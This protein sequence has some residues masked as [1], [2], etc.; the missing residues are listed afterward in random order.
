MSLAD[1]PT[2]EHLPEDRGETVGPARTPFQPRDVREGVTIGGMR[3]ERELAR[4]G[5]GVVYLAHEPGGRA[6]ALK[7]LQRHGSP[8]WLARFRREA[9]IGQRLEHPGIVRVH[10]IGQHEGFDYLVMELIEDAR[11]L[12][13]YVQEQGLDPT[14]RV[15]LM[16]QVC[17]ALQ[18]AHEEGVI[19]RD[20]KP[21]NLLVTPAGQV[22]VVDFGVAR[23]LE[24]SR[25][26]RTGALVGTPHFMAPEQVRHGASVAD[27][28]S[29]VFALGVILFQLMA[30]RLP[31]EGFSAPGVMASILLQE[32]PD[33][34]E[35]APDAPP[36]LS[37]VVTRALARDPDH[38]YASVAAL[39]Q[40]LAA[41]VAGRRIAEDTEA[42]ARRQRRRVAARKLG[43]VLVGASLVLGLGFFV[44]V[45]LRD[46][47]ATPATTLEVERELSRFLQRPSLFRDDAEQVLA[48]RARVEGPRLTCL[49]GLVALGRG[50]LAAARDALKRAEVAGARGIELLA[51]R[52]GVRLEDGAFAQARADLHRAVAKGATRPEVRAW[53]ARAVIASGPTLTQAARAQRDLE[54]LAKLRPATRKERLAM[55]RALRRLGRRKRAAAVLAELKE[56]PPELAWSLALDRVELLLERGAP[57]VALKLVAT[58]PKGDWQP[59]RR[60]RIADKAVASTYPWLNQ[61]TERTLA[62]DERLKLLAQLRVV[63]ALLATQASEP[64]Q[65]IKRLLR[66]VLRDHLDPDLAVAIADLVPHSI[67]FQERILWAFEGLVNSNHWR[68]RLLPVHR[69]LLRLASNPR[70]RATRGFIVCEWLDMLGDQA[71]AFK[72]AGQLLV[73]LEAYPKLRANFLVVRGRFLRRRSK[74]KA[75]LKL[76]DLALTLNRNLVKARFQRAMA[77]LALGRKEEALRQ[78]KRFLRGTYDGTRESDRA[79]ALIWDL[80]RANKQ[81]EAVVLEAV[82]TMVRS[83]PAYGGWKVRLALL[84]LE[85]GRTAEALKSLTRGREQL[86]Q[87]REAPQV[88]DALVRAVRAGKKKGLP[89]LRPFVKRLDAV[90]LRGRGLRP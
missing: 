79:V 3:V 27:A 67:A 70:Q 11:E 49:V 63:R 90:R 40:D 62:P 77:L 53:L 71:G 56:P 78:A 55:V 19:H 7:L 60:R 26:T 10:R 84:R 65:G 41:V 14:Q 33:L 28:R 9:D 34:R 6:V 89:A 69:R 52:G 81:H 47:R 45:L 68:R 13:Q 25:L 16:L 1:R 50:D 4:G 83:R 5:M 23:D 51:L 29:D 36:G 44:S 31:F 85:A 75:A 39:G 72:L 15:R 58:L 42:A 21:A 24:R 80:G 87:Q 66:V 64:P 82:R 38:R 30:G 12:N 86:V 32:L 61:H 59:A 54:A 76:L 46:G 48:W 20:L 43:F 17:D 2:E 88:S 73:G 37:E 18:A 22:K 35:H 8:E 57:R 74:P